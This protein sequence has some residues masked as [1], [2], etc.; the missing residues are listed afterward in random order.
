M[1][2]ISLILLALILS[3]TL[4]G[5]EDQNDAPPVEDVNIIA[6]K[7]PT[8]MGMVEMMDK[9]YA[10]YNFEIAASIDEV[11]PKVAKG[12]V[13][14]AAVP[15]NVASVLYNNTDKDVVVLAINTLGVLYICETG[16]SVKTI[17]DLSGK[18]IYA[19]GKGATPEYA[20]NYILEK[21]GISDDVNIEW[22]SEHSECVAAITSD[23]DA[24]AMLPQPFVTTAMMADHDI[25]VALDLNEEWEKLD[26]NALLTGVVI[27]NAEF[28]KN[29]EKVIDEFLDRYN[30]SVEYVNTD[31]EGAA[32]LIEKYDIVKKAVALKA[33]PECNIVLITGEKMKGLLSNYLTTLYDQ[34]PKAIGG[35]MPSDDFYYGAD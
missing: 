14:I 21:A 19:S 32:E 26:G 3:I 33:L 4:V 13:D 6:L 5:C 18:T 12:E 30:T 10:G 17:D 31:L 34:N 35:N 15:A 29:N 20:L 9:E 8:A 25:H 23:K 27:A 24:I 16:D 22:K 1:K 11:T 28:V 7:G 2:K